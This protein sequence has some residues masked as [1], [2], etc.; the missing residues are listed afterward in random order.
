MLEL[1]FLQGKHVF[2]IP[3]IVTDP[4]RMYVYTQISS[5]ETN[6]IPLVW[7]QH[8]SMVRSPVRK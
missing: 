2:S 4:S 5:L 7:H 1:S 8:N 6:I 3:G